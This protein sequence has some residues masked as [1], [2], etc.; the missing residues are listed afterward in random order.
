MKKR[1]YSSS[2]VLPWDCSSSLPLWTSLLIWFSCCC[3]HI[4]GYFFTEVLNPSKSSM[5]TGINFFQTPAPNSYESRMF[6]MASV[7]AN[8]FKVFSL[9]CLDLAKGLLSTEVVSLWNVFLHFIQ[10]KRPRSVAKYI[11]KQSWKEKLFLIYG[12][13]SR[14]F[15]GYEN[16]INFIIFLCEN[17]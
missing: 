9:L 12:F 3:C 14:C 5:K 8:I 6:L 1:S 4:Y 15:S 17:S 13:Q 16:N 10:P 7:I 2:T 11:V